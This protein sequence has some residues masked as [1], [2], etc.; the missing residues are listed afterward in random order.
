MKRLIAAFLLA[1][2]YPI[3]PIQYFRFTRRIDTPPAAAGQTCVVLD[4]QTFAHASPGLA[5]LRL[6]RGGDAVPYVVRGLAPRPV[7][8][9]TIPAI[10]LGRRDGKTV[11]DAEMPDLSYSD[12]QLDLIGQDFLATVKVS[13]SQNAGEAP[14]RVGSYTIFDFTNQ[15]LG[16]STILH[17]PRSNYRFLH[18]E[19]AGSIAPDQIKGLA[20]AALPAGETRYLTLAETAQFAQKGRSSVAELAI[21][22]NVPVDRVVFD[23]SQDPVNF[24]RAVTVDV[25]EL[26]PKAAD[27]TLPDRPMTIA[28]GD[29]LRIHR[30]YAGRRVDEERVAIT[31]PD[32]AHSDPAKLTI[33]IA[34]GDDAPIQFTGVHLQMVEHDLCFEA[35]EGFIYDLYYG[36]S[37]LRLPHYD[38][39]SWYTPAARPVLATLGPE[40]LNPGYQPR[41]DARPFSERHPVLLW[42]ALVAVILLLGAIALLSARRMQ[43]PAQMP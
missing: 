21:P 11:F 15:K 42:M 43:P 9:Q 34:N 8:R 12:V 25:T 20:A 17:L 30:T 41:P 16:R 40:R 26:K 18:F 38:Y 10:N 5:D 13:G 36:D 4:E 23:V 31:L 14:T 35:T 24:S 37:T 3:L 33:T 39:A 19:I 29:I 1:A 7:L 22:A 27:E 2:A 32:E 28:F 6:F